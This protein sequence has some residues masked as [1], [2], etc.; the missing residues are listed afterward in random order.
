[1]K[2]VGIY[3]RVSTQEQADEGYSIQEQTERLKKY[4]EAMKWNVIQIYTDGGFTG[5]NTNRPALSR[6]IADTK[7]GQVDIVLVYKLDRLSRSQKDTLFL[8][9]D[10]FLKNNVEFVSMSENFDTSSPF[11]RAMIGILSVF[12]QLEREQIKERLAMG[13]LGRAK[14][15]YWHG[16]GGAPIGYDFIDGKLVIDE[17]EALQIK[18]VFDLFLQG[19]SMHGICDIMRAKYSNKYSS[20]NNH[21]AIA[22][23]LRNKMYIGIIKYKK[24]EYIGQHDPIIETEVFEL[25]Q[26]KLK[27]YQKTFTEHNKTPFRGNNLLSGVVFCGSCGARYFVATTTSKKR[28]T[29]QYYK[30]YSRDGNTKMKKVDGCKNPNYTKS[31]LDGIIT[32]QILELAYDETEIDNLI[33]TE[34]KSNNRTSTFSNRIVEI[35]KQINKLM[36]LYQVG[37]IPIEQ[38]GSRIEPLQREKDSLNAEIKSNV[39]P[40]VLSPSA[41]KKI[42]RKAEKILNGDN[43]EKKRELIDSLIRNIVI[44]PNEITIHWKFT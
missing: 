37:N 24:V 23:I 9:E 17:Y 41:T 25:V 19:K 5:S 38:I 14:E 7:S 10:V 42:I 36:D 29:Y 39:E 4:S 26:D 15:G 28:G 2:R 13:H 35:E 11:G 27:E 21:G 16:G 20:W 43:M 30:C 40:T 22:K 3:I 32:N 31:E 34:Y 8:I 33:R 12:A 6:L 18:E 1:M 44:Y